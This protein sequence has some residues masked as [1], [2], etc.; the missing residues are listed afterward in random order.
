MER[1]NPLNA[2]PRVIVIY[3]PAPGPQ[4]GPRKSVLAA[5]VV[6]LALGG[7]IGWYAYVATT[8]YRNH[9]RAV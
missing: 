6:G 3:A 5:Y 1:T 4:P 9:L 2:D 8:R 7:A